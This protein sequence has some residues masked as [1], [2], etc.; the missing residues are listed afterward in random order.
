MA[1][2]PGNSHSHVAPL[3]DWPWATLW[4]A[5]PVTRPVLGCR[6]VFKRECTPSAFPQRALAASAR[7]RAS[8]PQ[9]AVIHTRQRSAQTRPPPLQGYRRRAATGVKGA[10]LIRAHAQQH[11]GLGVP[12]LPRGLHRDGA[13]FCRRDLRRGWQRLIRRASADLGR[14][15]ESIIRVNSPS[16]K[17]GITYLLKRDYHLVLPRRL[18]I[19]GSRAV[20]AMADASGKELSSAQRRLRRM[21]HT[22]PRC[23]RHPRRTSRCV[24]H[25]RA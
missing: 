1:Q 18:L 21:P 5:C 24:G 23:G 16:G 14:S 9:G 3:T 2:A 17:G 12:V 15:Y 10:E 22:S 4:G 7:P 13:R 25:Q 19:E 6:H 8:A 11:P 20:Q